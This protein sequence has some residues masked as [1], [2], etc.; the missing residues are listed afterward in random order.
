MVQIAESDETRP[1]GGKL[2]NNQTI[3][4]VGIALTD[5]CWHTYAQTQYV[6]APQL[7][8]FE[9]AAHIPLLKRTGIGPESFGFISKDGNF[10]GP[11]DIINSEQATFARQHGF[12]PRSSGYILRPEV[13]ESNFY[14]W[15]ATGNTKYLDRAAAAIKSL[16]QHLRIDT[17]YPGLQNVNRVN[18]GFIDDMESFWF[19]ETLKY[20]YVSHL[21]KTGLLLTR[22]LCSRFLTFDD[23]ARFS[24]EDCE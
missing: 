23:P 24:L 13:L 5:G 12:Y 16:N 18:G 11:G 10:T 21:E 20:L 17:G 6:H 14:A 4:D 19:A 7:P 22:L 2:L 3:V 8:L 9:T 1:L 15:R